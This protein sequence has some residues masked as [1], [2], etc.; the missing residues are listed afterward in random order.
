L[1]GQLLV[2]GQPADQSAFRSELAGLYTMITLVNSLVDYYEVR[3]GTV[4]LACDGIQALEYVFDTKKS[5]TAA[6]NSYDLI[7]EIRK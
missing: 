3:N 6:S 4:E 1:T 5:I 2:P 7:L